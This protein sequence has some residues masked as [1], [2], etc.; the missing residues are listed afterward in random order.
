M[1]N[2]INLLRI[3]R[4][5]AAFA[6]PTF[7][8]SDGAYAKNKESVIHSFSGGSDGGYPSAALIKDK[9]GN[10]YGTTVGGGGGTDGNAGVVFKVTPSGQLTTLHIFQGTDGSAPKAG[11]IADS[12]G[13][14][15]GTTFG[16]GTAN[17]GTV[18]KLAPNGSVTVLHSFLGGTDGSQPYAALAS[19]PQGNL[20]GTAGGGAS[21]NGVVFKVT[22]DGDETILYTFSGTTDGAYPG[23]AQLFIDKKRN[24]F[25]TTSNGGAYT[26]GTI[27]EVTQKGKETV[28]YSF[29]GY[30][31]DSQSPSAGVVM[32]SDGSLYGTTSGGGDQGVGTVFKFTSLGQESVVYSFAGGADGAYPNSNV[33]IDKTGNLYG[34]TG[35]GG[36]GGGCSCGTVFK[37]AAESGSES[38]LHIF[39]NVGVDG[40]EPDSLTIDRKD[41]LYGTT[42]YGGT[43]NAGS[44]FK[45]NN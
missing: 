23:A 28:L 25:G 15:Y 22:G 42:F 14:F 35:G 16:G 3:S 37:I 32:D 20:Y 43:S 19:D 11:L 26:H 24:L 36:N 27:F 8:L 41:D 17:L 29:G 13:N 30:S 5:A 7:F 12:K 6:V 2:G 44:V 10:F 31:G 9:D 1:P 33:V 21:G 40:W 45:V 38:V 18:F 4:W 34:V 39:S